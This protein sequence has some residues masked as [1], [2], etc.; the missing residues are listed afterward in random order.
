MIK[1]H[2]SFLTV[3]GAAMLVACSSGD[4]GNGNGGD[5]IDS[6]GE[7]S[8]LTG[9]FIDSP[10]EGLSFSTA[11]QSGT[12]GAA[13]EFD[14]QSGET[15]TFAIG[16]IVLGSA[17]GREVVTPLDLAG[18]TD[19]NADRVVNI[20]RLLQALDENGDPEDGIRVPP[21][22]VS[23]AEGLTLDFDLPVTE[24]ENHINVV[25]YVANAG[26]GNVTLVAAADAIAHFERAL[27]NISDDGGDI[28]GCDPV[29]GSAD[30]TINVSA[31]GEVSPQIEVNGPDGFFTT[32]TSTDT[33]AGLPVG[34]YSI[35]ALPFRV[36]HAIVDDLYRGVISSGLVCLENASD[37]IVSISYEL[38]PASNKLWVG[39][40]IGDNR[41]H[42]YSGVDL[43]ASGSPAPAYAFNNT[44]MSPNAVAFDEAGTLWV[45]DVVGDGRIYGYTPEDIEE[46]EPVPSITINTVE[47]GSP[48]GLA[49]DKDGSLWATAYFDN[50]LIKFTASQLETSG[51]PVPDLTINGLDQPGALAFDGSGN[52]WVAN[53]G[54]SSVVKYNAS[55]LVTS[56]SPMP[57]VTFTSKRR[58]ASDFS[59]LS[60]SALAFNED[61]DLVIT[62]SAS[63]A[64]ARYDSQDLPSSS[65]AYVPSSWSEVVSSVMHG[66]AFDESGDLWVALGLNTIHKYSLNNIGTDSLSPLTEINGIGL[67]YPEG[68]AFYPP[69]ENLPIAQ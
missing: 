55:Q 18:T 56:G 9:Q 10:V 42:A 63:N 23:A 6:A 26:G 67:E 5:D 13:G 7:T 30:L 46:E 54:D 35:S 34:G 68:I 38:H 20:I 3:A 29:D 40:N 11:T 41:V 44:F 53:N 8:V 52:L 19:V 60:P 69:P 16:D 2:K 22:A 65:G 49:F 31:P 51:S 57:A 25:N 24:F 58:P 45:A 12:T 39:N 37:E 14:Y 47:G 50:T 4:G 61:G 27:D 17:E 32:L 33:L 43:S 64:I 15:V 62:Y 1:L 28:A 36:H 66:V 21:E 48:H 59:L